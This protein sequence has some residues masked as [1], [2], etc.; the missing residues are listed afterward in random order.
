MNKSDRQPVRR[1]VLGLPG[2][3]S[4]LSRAREAGMTLVEVLIA[5][6]LFA[7]VGLIAVAQVSSSTRTLIHVDDENRGLADAKVVLDRLSRDI[8]EARGVVCDKGLADPT[9][10]TSADPTCRAH[11]QL[12]IDDNSDYLQQPAEV[13]T[14]RL[15]HRPDEH[16]DVWRVTSAG[17]HL[18]ASALIVQT[19]FEYNAATP[20][21]SNFVT[22]HMMYDAISGLGSGAR[23]AAVS[24]RLRNKG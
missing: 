15:T 4:P 21:A 19:L 17:Q 18:Q 5:M 24:V 20:E 10:P 1:A 23:E 3:R 16:F 7:T 11:L 8:R 9:D 13:V 22:V 6:T 2:S 14:W 12:W